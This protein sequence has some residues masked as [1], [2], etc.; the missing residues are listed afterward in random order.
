MKQLDLVR[1]TAGGIDLVVE[2]DAGNVVKIL[3]GKPSVS[4]KF[5][6]ELCNLAERALAELEGDIDMPE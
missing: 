4:L 5:W 3:T 2:R 6:D 1:N